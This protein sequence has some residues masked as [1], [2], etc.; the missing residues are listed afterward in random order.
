M[1]ICAARQLRST[2]KDQ[3]QREQNLDHF[4][5]MVL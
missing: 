5:V 3:G 1:L 2:K 4:P